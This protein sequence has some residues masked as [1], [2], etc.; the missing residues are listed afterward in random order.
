ML[1]EET[2]SDNGLEIKFTASIGS[3]QVK[4]TDTGFELGDKIGLFA[5]DPV[6]ANNLPLTWNGA[7]MVPESKL[8]WAP[9][10]EESTWFA[11][12]YPYDPNRE[13]TWSEFTVNADQ[14]TRELYEA[15]DLLAATNVAYMKDGVVNFIFAHRLTKIVL[16]VENELE[17]ASI[18]EVY[19]G[20]VQGR[21]QGS[22]DGS[23]EGIGLPGTVK[24]GSVTLSADGAPAWTCIVPPQYSRPRLVIKTTDERQFSY[25]L[26]Q[27]LWLSGGCRYTFHVLLDKGTISVDSTPEVTEWTDNNDIAFPKRGQSDWTLLGTGAGRLPMVNCVDDYDAYYALIAYEEGQTLTFVK[28]GEFAYGVESTEYQYDFALKADG[29]G[30]VLPRSG[31]Y[32][33][34]LCP[35][36]KYVAVVE[37]SREHT[38]GVTGT[39]EKLQWNRD[40]YADFA[41][42]DTVDGVATPILGFSVKYRADEMFKFRF[43]GNWFLEFG[44]DVNWNGDF[45][46]ILVPAE[47]YVPVMY[48]GANISLP[49]DGY[50]DLYLDVNNA[51]M[52]AIK[53]ADL[54]PVVPSLITIDGDFSDWDQLDPAKVSVAYSL[55]NAILPA[56]KLMKA[57]ADDNALFIYF[58][59]NP[60]YVTPEQMFLDV[61][62][63][64][65]N[66]PKTGFRSGL[67]KDCGIDLLLEGCLYYDYEMRSFEPYLYR[68]C[69]IDGEQDWSWEE[70]NVYD[71]AT[72]EGRKYAY[73][74]RIDRGVVD[75]P[76]SFSVGLNLMDYSWNTVGGLPSTEANPT[77]AYM[78]PVNT[79]GPGV[80][81]GLPE[82]EPSTYYAPFNIS[83]A[84]DY[85]NAGGT[86][87]VYV[88]GIVS[89]TIEFSAQYGNVTFWLSDDGQYYNDPSMDF[90]VYRAYWF[91]G[92]KWQE[93]DIEAQ[94]GDTVVVYGF[95][96]QYK[97]FCETAAGKA[98]V[99]TVNGY[100]GEDSNLENPEQGEEWG[101]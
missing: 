26:E 50:Y 12:Y 22:I 34:I 57:Y 5:G 10:Q 23:F 20:N 98:Y 13:Y 21:V 52:K 93:G 58:E 53:T 56:L 37:G 45:N 84:I 62:L 9:G 2:V 43:M 51:R 28:N 41:F 96:S 72:G 7:N 35:E 79:G 59:M 42:V 87:E 24:A 32:E 97:G 85:Y 19:I 99:V 48:Q 71:S 69:G 80:V 33:V 16:L 78:L 100:D 44:A 77:D 70:L 88:K 46:S 60:D 40:H 54:P 92:R 73:E 94:E 14:S 47:E 75:L 68:Y 29:E 8:F 101:W 64:S 31:V 91:G 66:N 27:E 49:E 76:D 63:D 6:R 81:I 18:A 39:L 67:W 3:F 95:L 74:I 17:D 83:Q 25:D 38:W 86:K 11:A 4:A 55:E 1:P 82:P 15:S 90:E 61:L 36:D 65:D 89:K 30:I